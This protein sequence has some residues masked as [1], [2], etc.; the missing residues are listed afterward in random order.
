MVASFSLLIQNQLILRM[1]KTLVNLK[2]EKR[3]SNAIA[4]VK[5]S[6][7][8]LDADMPYI[9]VKVA[10]KLTQ[11]QRKEIVKDITDTM[12]RVAGKPASSTYV[13]IDEIPRNQWGV[14]GKML[15][16]K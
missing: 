6:W 4:V 2:I 11:K 15:S 7:F 13:Q 14:G 3:T 9:N 10:G 1:V 5:N 8:C 12:L 16:E